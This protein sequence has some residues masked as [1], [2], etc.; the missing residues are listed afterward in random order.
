M[1]KLFFDNNITLN[2]IYKTI[3]AEIGTPK[4]Y[5]VIQYYNSLQK[6]KKPIPTDLK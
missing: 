2:D 4:V 1:I 6:P 3:K 5:L